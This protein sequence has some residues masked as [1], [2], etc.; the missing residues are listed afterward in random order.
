[1]EW[2][3]ERGLVTTGVSVTV[4]APVSDT[5]TFTVGLGMVVVV[6]SVRIG[7]D[8]GVVEIGMEV[9]GGGG[10]KVVC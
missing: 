8:K 6:D 1:M 2:I 5:L 4:V 7:D 9:M 3:G 10:G